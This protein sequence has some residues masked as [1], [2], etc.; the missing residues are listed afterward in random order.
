MPAY[1]LCWFLRIHGKS[2][3]SGTVFIVG[4]ATDEFNS[5]FTYGMLQKLLV[6]V[7]VKQQQLKSLQSDA[8]NLQ[9][10]LS[11]DLT[12]LVHLVVRHY[13]SNSNVPGT[14][15][16]V[17]LQLKSTLPDFRSLSRSVRCFIASNSSCCSIASCLYVTDNANSVSVPRTVKERAAR[18]RQN[19]W[20]RDYER[21]HDRRAR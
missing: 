16:S 6:W 13:D 17:P 8:G 4:N 9:M 20:Y 18:L 2:T 14:S 3:S 15:S 1:G 19:P 11:T 5:Y 10:S 12:S 21:L 7:K